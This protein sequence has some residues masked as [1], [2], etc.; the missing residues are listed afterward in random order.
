MKVPA[1][2]RVM[3]TVE[4][5]NGVHRQSRR[6]RSFCKRGSSGCR[7]LNS[8]AFS[9]GAALQ[10]ALVSVLAPLVQPEEE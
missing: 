10:A 3:S 2:Y 5:A 8:P 6:R 4:I 9:I 7:C 1:F